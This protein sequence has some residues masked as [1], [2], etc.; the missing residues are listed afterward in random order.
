MQQNDLFNEVGFKMKSLVVL[1]LILCFSHKV[2]A[3]KKSKTN[4]SAVNSSGWKVFKSDLGWEIQYP[5]CLKPSPSFSFELDDD[6]KKLTTID[7]II[8]EKNSCDLL[9]AYASSACFYS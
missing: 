7:F 8:D 1:A 3:D 5:E 4:A 6:V 2:L 9:P